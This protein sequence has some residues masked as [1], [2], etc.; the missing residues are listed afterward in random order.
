MNS[1]QE[2]VTIHQAQEIVDNWIKDIGVRYFS[3]LT[4]LAQ[5][6]EEVGELSRIMSRKY[7][8]QS[9]KDSDKGASL[10]D[11]LADVLFVL[12]C[13]ANQTDVDLT[14]AFARNIE[15][16]TNRD[17]QRHKSNPKLAPKS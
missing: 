7:G 16:K 3:E 2:T 11:E 13:I 12:I 5:L 10:D 6:M 9:F 17:G 15:K 1:T 4:N 8:E 14:E